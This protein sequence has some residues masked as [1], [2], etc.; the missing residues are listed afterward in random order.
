MIYLA[1]SHWKCE[2]N[3]CCRDASE[4]FSWKITWLCELLECWSWRSFNIFLE[5]WQNGAGALAKTPVIQ[6]TPSFLKYFF[7]LILSKVSCMQRGN[8]LFI[9]LPGIKSKCRLFYCSAVKTS[10][11]LTTKIQFLRIIWKILWENT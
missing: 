6:L 10:S 1:Y 3:I 8:A 9:T 5:V 4:S 2:I 7:F 11:V